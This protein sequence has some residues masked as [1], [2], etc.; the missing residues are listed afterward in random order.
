MSLPRSKQRALDAWE[1]ACVRRDH[2]ASTV[3][4]RRRSVVRFLRAFAG[5]HLG[6]LTTADLEG[7]L[8]RLGEHAS[9]ATQA[10]E[11]D[12]LRGFLALLVEEGVIASTRM[13]DVRVRRAER[14]PRLVPSEPAVARLLATASAHPRWPW[15][16]LRDRAA[17]EVLYGV[18]VRAAEVRAAL[19]VDLDLERGSL[20]VRR[21]KRGEQRVL[22]LPPAAVPHLR[23]YVTEARPR[24]VGFGGGHDRGH[25]LLSNVGRPLGEDAVRRLVARVAARAGVRATPHAIR[26]GTATHL[27]RSG[28]PVT[29][30]QALLGH[31]R[32]DSTAVYVDL[33]REDLRR[34]VDQLDRR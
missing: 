12:V 6:W 34:A 9:A 11:A 8:A 28:V 14:P 20:L 16:G 3:R 32:L 10:A 2:A 21:V 15:A 33:D 25:L 4:V 7:Y 23:A 30:V 22:P 13:A 24:L 19:L 18:G 26:R 17:L 29:A 1:R 27:V 5:R 31:E